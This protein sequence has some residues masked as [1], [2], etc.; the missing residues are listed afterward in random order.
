VLARAVQRVLRSACSSTIAMVLRADSVAPRRL[1]A[2]VSQCASEPDLIILLDGSGSLGTFGW[3][4]SVT[5]VSY[6]LAGLKTGDDSSLSRRS[7]CGVEWVAR[8]TN[9]TFKARRAV[10]KL[11]YPAGATLSSVAFAQ[12]EQEE[13]LS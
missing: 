12:A 5:F 9:D 13:L 3:D 11:T 8:F 1:R 4:K 10:T 6:L 2:K 7:Y